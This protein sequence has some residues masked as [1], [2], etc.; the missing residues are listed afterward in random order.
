MNDYKKQWRIKNKEKIK[1]YNKQYRL[2]NKDKID[3]WY[4]EHP[5]Y[6][7]T[8]Q[9]NNKEKIKKQRKNYYQKT[10]KEKWENY[11]QKNRDRLLKNHQKK[12]KGYKK[13][14]IKLIN[15][16]YGKIQ[17]QRCG[18]KKIFRNIDFHHR[19]PKEKEYPI[20]SFFANKPSQKRI[21][22]LKEEIKKCDMLCK[23][24]H[25]EHHY[26]KDFIDSWLL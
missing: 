22:I 5:N 19:D 12:V 16:H 10:G 1:E 18:Y 9:K 6:N 14:W 23:I 25:G 2:K 13:Q 20:S 3:K 7:K 8:Y 24:C 26:P 11:Y 21:E 17:C 4:E 15:E